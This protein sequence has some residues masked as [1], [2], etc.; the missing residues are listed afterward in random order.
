VLAALW[1]VLNLVEGAK[2]LFIP[3]LLEYQV[4]GISLPKML[5]NVGV[6][7]VWSEGFADLGKLRG[8]TNFWTAPPK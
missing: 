1:A 4:Q 7:V 5:G 6:E 8:L 3:L 2:L